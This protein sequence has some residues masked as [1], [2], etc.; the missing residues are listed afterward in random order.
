MDTPVTRQSHGLEQFFAS[1]SGSSGLRI[2]DLGGACQ[3]NITYI[4]SL[5]HRLSSEDFLRTLENVFGEGDFYSNQEREDLVEVFTGQVL[6]FKEGY[7]DGVLVW[8]TLQY[9]SPKLLQMTLHQLHT[10]LQPGALMLSFFHTDEKATTAPMLNFRI[11]DSRNLSLES[12]G[13]RKPA[14]F[15]NNRTLERLFDHYHS[16]KFFLTRDNLREVI[17]RR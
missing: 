5:G 7:F 2:L 9:L 17:V 14:Q 1:L 16:T 8:D 4:T 11:Q 6:D 15:F 10:I 3:E 12:R 13:I